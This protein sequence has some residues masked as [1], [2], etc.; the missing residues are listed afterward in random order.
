LLWLNKYKDT[1]SKLTRWSLLLQEYNFD[2]IHCNGRDNEFADFLSRNPINET[3][4]LGQISTERLLPPVNTPKIANNVKKVNGNIN[5]ITHYDL[6]NRIA[7]AQRRSLPLQRKISKWKDI[8]TSGAKNIQERRFYRTYWVNNKEGLLFKRGKNNQL[9]VP[10]QLKTTVIHFHH[11]TPESAHPGRDETVRKI[12][13][14]YF[15]KN[16]HKNVGEYIHNC[17]V[18]MSVKRRQV[19]KEAP[20]RAHTPHFP[21]EI[22][23]IDIL[24]P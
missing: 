23:S 14:K 12:L 22:L 11:D 15:F 8:D 17:I 2:L 10:R 20:L 16:I 3:F 18:C 24:G 6:Y 5:N 9:V 1:K 7:N 13:Q 21:F 19:Q 4:D